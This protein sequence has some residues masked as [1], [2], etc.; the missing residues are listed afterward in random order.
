MTP[1]YDPA[2]PVSRGAA[3]A[4]EQAEREGEAGRLGPRPPRLDPPPAHGDP[5]TGRHGMDD[6]TA[7]PPTAAF[8]PPRPSGP[9]G[10]SGYQQTGVFPGG[11]PAAQVTSAY[12]VSGM[13]PGAPVSA[14]PTPPA[15]P[16]RRIHLAEVSLVLVLVLLAISAFQGFL[17]YQ[18]RHD[19]SE[20]KRRAATER[21]QAEAKAQG[22]EARIKELERRAGN[23]LDA[24]A[25]AGD[26]LPSVFLVKAGG[27]T[28]T[29]FAFGAE[30]SDGGTQLLTN[31]HVVEQVYEK[32]GREVGL[33]QQNRRFTAKVV[34]V[35]PQ[36]DLALLQV[37]EKFPRLQPSP[38]PARPGQPVVVVG[39]PLGLGDSVTSGVVSALRETQRGQVLQFDAPVN[40]GNSGGPVVNAQKQVVGIVNAKLENAEGISLGIPVAVA[41]QALSIC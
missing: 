19:L 10:P 7:R 38:E 24:A 40:R 23:T 39:A 32:G 33:E 11:P 36:A 17:L 21:T 12:P 25:V 9:Q 1:G 29:G 30:T 27:L 41:C 15:A 28:G 34:K 6:R 18:T 14:Y 2:S 37:A 31:Y 35:D 13:H 26:V 22:N 3:H 5:G 20:T 4:A 8:G 16:R